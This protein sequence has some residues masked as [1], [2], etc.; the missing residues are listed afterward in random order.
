[1]VSQNIRVAFLIL[2]LVA[3]CSRSRVTKVNVINSSS[4]KISNII[5]DYPSATF[6]VRLLAPGK[7]FQYAIKVTE[8]GALKIEFTDAQGKIRKFPGPAVR[9]DDEGNIEIKLTQDAAV[10]DTKLQPK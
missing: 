4:D 10:V 6:G 8:D 1:M 2:V 9:K 7:T 3:G 5:I